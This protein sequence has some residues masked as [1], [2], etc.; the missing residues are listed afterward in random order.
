M[1]KIAKNIWSIF[2]LDYIY[3]F[4]C[5]VIILYIIYLYNYIIKNLLM[6]PRANNL[7]TEVA[8]SENNT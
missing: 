6:T 1:Q 5:Y 4:F 8:H 2:F 3:D 7:R